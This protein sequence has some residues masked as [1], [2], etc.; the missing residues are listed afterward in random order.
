[1]LLGSIVQYVVIHGAERR[2]PNNYNRQPPER[3]QVVE[4]RVSQQVRCRNVFVSFDC[5]IVLVQ[6]GI[7]NYC[8]II[9]L[10]SIQGNSFFS[11]AKPTN[12]PRRN[13]PSD[14]LLVLLDFN[15]H[16]VQ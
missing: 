1:L 6:F 16:V 9:S 5:S 15:S 4:M 12:K 2:S 3:P 10:Y 7:T 11:D 8:I 13:M 14:S